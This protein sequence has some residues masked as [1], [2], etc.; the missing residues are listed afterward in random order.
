[1]LL[2]FL[3]FGILCFWLNTFLH[4]WKFGK[5]Q[6]D[7]RI[8]TQAMLVPLITGPSLVGVKGTDY[9]ARAEFLSSP[10]VPL[11]FDYAFF[12]RRIL[13]RAMKGRFFRI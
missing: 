4:A 6:T 10:A 5:G 13:G 12:S 9:A 1:M 2:L 11:N 3:Q 8:A 7:E